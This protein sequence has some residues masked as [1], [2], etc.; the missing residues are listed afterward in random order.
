MYYFKI[1]PQDLN[2]AQEADGWW[3]LR[4]KN[5]ESGLWFRL[6]HNANTNPRGEPDN[7]MEFE[8][9]DADRA[10]GKGA[11]FTV[12]PNEWLESFVFGGYFNVWLSGRGV[13]IV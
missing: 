9:Y 6:R 1:L 10:L 7:M 13:R 4:H 12:N 11:Q 5:P 2:F 8:I 3:T